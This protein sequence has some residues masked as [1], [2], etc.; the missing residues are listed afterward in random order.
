MS[1]GHDDFR[2]DLPRLAVISQLAVSPRLSIPEPL[3]SSSGY[4]DPPDQP[5]KSLL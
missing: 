4:T 2:F 5:P 1:N 3:P